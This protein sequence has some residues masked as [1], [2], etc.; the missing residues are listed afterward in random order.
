MSTACECDRTAEQPNR[1]P[2]SPGSISRITPTAPRLQRNSWTESSNVH[3]EY[4]RRWLANPKAVL[5]QTS[6]PVNLPPTGDPMGQDL[7]HGTSLQQLEAVRDLLLNFDGHL[8][9]RASLC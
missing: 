7:I 3:P 2:T 6:M 1:R 5:P 9:G 8:R 4:V